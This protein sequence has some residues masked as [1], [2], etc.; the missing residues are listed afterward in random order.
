MWEGRESYRRTTDKP[1]PKTIAQAAAKLGITEGAV[2]GR[3]KRGTLP[4]A[5]DAGTGL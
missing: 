3:I 5:I 1:T 2:R 4:A